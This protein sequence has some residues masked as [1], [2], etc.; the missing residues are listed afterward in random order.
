[1]NPLTS[2]SLSLIRI[3]GGDGAGPGKMIERFFDRKENY[4]IH[5]V[6]IYTIATLEKWS[7]KTWPKLN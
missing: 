7:K 2:A 4:T 6:E 1:M 5:T 3:L